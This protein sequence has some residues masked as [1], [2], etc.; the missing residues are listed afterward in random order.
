MAAVTTMAHEL[1][2][3]WQ[4]SN[5]D[6]DAIAHRY[7][8]ANLLAVS[9]GMATWAMVQYLLFVR[10]FDFAR[11][12]E[13]YAMARD[14]EYG[15]GFRIFSERYPLRVDGDIDEDTPFQGPFPL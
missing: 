7:G 15:I 12:Q 8:K 5:W 14:D 9:E 10:D 6:L 13:A 1:T 3:I 4:F 2:H 11:R